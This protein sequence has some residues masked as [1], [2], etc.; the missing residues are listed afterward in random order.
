MDLTKRFGETSTEG[1]GGIFNNGGVV[2]ITG[3][4]TLI[5]DNFA[6]GTSGSGG[7]LFNDLGGE[8]NITDATITGN[9]ANRAGGGIE[10]VAG[11]TTNLT[12]VILSENN[13]GVGPDAV[14]A[15][16]NGGGLHITGAGDATIVGGE[17]DGNVAASEG[18]GLWNGTGTL[19]VDGTLIVGN[20]AS[21]A[22]ADEGGGGIFNAGGALDVNSVEF[23]GNRADGTS[24]SGGG[25]L[26]NAGSVE[27]TDS[28]FSLNSANRAG[29]A[30]ED[31]AGTL[32]LQDSTI[33]SNQALSNPG[34]G[35]GVHITGASVVDINS[36]LL[37]QNIA[38]NE[39]GGIWN[40]TLGQ[41]TLFE[42]IVDAN[43][44]PF[45]AGVFADGTGGI[46]SITASTLSRN[47]ALQQGGGLL[48]EGGET[49]I[50]NSTLSTNFASQG[51]GIA[52]LDGIT[53]LVSATIAANI[54]S[55]A[56]GGVMVI[57]GTLNA[58]NTLI[59]NNSA[60]AGPDG[61][62]QLTSQGNNLVGN[63]ADL[64][65]LGD[66]T[67]NIVG[68]NPGIGPLQDNGGGTQTHG[69]VPTSPARDSGSASAP[70]LDQ[71]GVLRP[72]G[73]EFDIGAFELQDSTSFLGFAADANRDGSISSIDAL[74]V[75]NELNG[76]SMLSDG[77]DVNG[78]GSVSPLDALL[79]VNQL[80][81][82]P[83]LPSQMDERPF[84]PRELDSKIEQ[85]TASVPQILLEAL[86]DEDQLEDLAYALAEHQLRIQ[87]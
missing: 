16:G 35:G 13:A 38:S 60:G 33:R 42:S 12:D 21:G 48:S 49:T 28:V 32:L 1:G 20:T 5:S 59:G 58:F 79:V 57:G 6:S 45:G 26:N 39:G 19:V 61:F 65:I 2:N 29:G 72:Q 31:L 34:N 46:L 7:G 36:T 25:L 41:L 51:G 80:N 63:S 8:L 68:V 86:D 74:I 82:G 56:G 62:G 54:G 71:R 44:A 64:Q 24:G 78:D 43:V 47:S 37:G 66:A 87:F 11:T 84:D 70:A 73:D 75:I 9:V 10:A 23:V 30:I 53:S 81:R 76:Q 17:V 18:G 15:P 50:T 69:L 67:G 52:V 22:A 40:S 77:A 83:G 3:A 55:A 14:A 4:D 27:I 85:V